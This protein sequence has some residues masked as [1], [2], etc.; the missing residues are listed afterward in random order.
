MLA[1]PLM[2]PLAEERPT[3]EAPLA[4]ELPAGLG[5]EQMRELVREVVQETVERLCREMF[6]AV[7]T[8]VVSREIA[9]LKKSL[10][11]ED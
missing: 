6:P 10:E 9:A 2:T 4:Q 8:E 5:E 1:A 3:P 7:A 11:E